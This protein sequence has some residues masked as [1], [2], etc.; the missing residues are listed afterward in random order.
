MNNKTI[1]KKGMVGWLKVKALI[2]N[3]S[4][5]VRIPALCRVYHPIVTVINGLYFAK[6]PQFAMSIWLKMK[7][8]LWVI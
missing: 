7:S 4:G 2:S 8:A 6:H 1:K 3:S 5:V